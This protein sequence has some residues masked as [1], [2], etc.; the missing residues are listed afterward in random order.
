LGQKAHESLQLIFRTIYA[1]VPEQAQL[2][3]S[4]VRSKINS[5]GNVIDAATAEGIKTLVDFF[6][7]RLNKAM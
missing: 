3:I 6:I 5:E 4:G 2:L 7:G 1:D